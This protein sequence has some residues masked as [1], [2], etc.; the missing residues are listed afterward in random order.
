M[1]ALHVILCVVYIEVRGTRAKCAH[2]ASPVNF[3]IIIGWYNL[4]SL[5][6]SRQFMDYFLRYPDTKQK[7]HKSKRISYALDLFE[8]ALKIATDL[9]KDII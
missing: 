1:K 9:H 4:K 5:K 3:H 7:K 6:L 2:E 8:P